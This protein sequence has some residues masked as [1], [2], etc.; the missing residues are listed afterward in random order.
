[1]NETDI[2]TWASLTQLI[3]LFILFQAEDFDKMSGGLE[4]HNRH[5]EKSVRVCRHLILYCILI[6]S[7]DQIG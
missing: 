4:N 6:E 7:G 2:T 1:M 5:K 3:K